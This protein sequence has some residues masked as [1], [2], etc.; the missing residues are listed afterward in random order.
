VSVAEAEQVS[1]SSLYAVLGLID[2]AP[3]TGAVL[4]TV[5]DALPVAVP[6]SASVAVAVQV[7]TSPGLLDAV[8]VKLAPVA[9]VD[10]A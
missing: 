5:A 1:S 4:D 8:S 10:H 9:P 7:S 3:I 2:T 6:L